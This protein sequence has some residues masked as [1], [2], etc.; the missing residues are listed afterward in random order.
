MSAKLWKLLSSYE[1]KE[2]QGR[3]AELYEKNWGDKAHKNKTRSWDAFAS[4]H[5]NQDPRTYQES[6]IF[7]G[8]WHDGVHGLVGTGEY[9][10]HMGD[11]SVAAVS[12]IRSST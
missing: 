9:N 11:P 7:L 8:S 10:G 12:K 2:P 1:W 4:H 6:A 5:I 3:D